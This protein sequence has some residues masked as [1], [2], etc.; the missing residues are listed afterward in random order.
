MMRIERLPAATIAAASVDRS[1]E[2]KNQNRSWE[3]ERMTRQRQD[4]TSAARRQQEWRQ[5]VTRRFWP[6][7]LTDSIPEC[8][9]FPDSVPGRN[10]R[11]RTRMGAVR[12][13]TRKSP[14][15]ELFFPKLFIYRHLVK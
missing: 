8:R 12:D 9:R 10:C 1:G 14:T 7:T 4:K 6:C 2:S 5:T 15:V 11:L 3:E 13:S